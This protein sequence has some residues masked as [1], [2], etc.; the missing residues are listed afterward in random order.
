MDN[1]PILIGKPTGW[2]REGHGELIYEVAQFGAGHD[3]SAEV[4]QVA[5][6]VTPLYER[7]SGHAH[8]RPVRFY[9]F[10][11]TPGATNTR[12]GVVA[13]YRPGEKP[14]TPL[15]KHLIAHELFHGWLGSDFVQADDTVAWFHEGFTDYLSLWH[16]A[17]SGVIDPGWFATRLIA[18][19]AEARQSPAYG[20]VAFAEKGINWRSSAN[21][22]LAYRGGAVLAFLIDVGL[23]KQG[24]PGLMQLV[25]D[26]GA[27][28]LKGPPSLDEI[29][30]WMERHGLES[31]YKTLVG[32]K[33][34]P[35]IADTLASIGF[36]PKDVPVELTYF[37]IRVE[38]D[39]IAELDPKGPAAQAGFRIGDRIV[40]RFPGSRAEP[41][42][43]SERLT[44]P[45]RYGLENV[46]PGVAGTYLDVQ[47]GAEELTI[48]VQPRVIQGGLASRYV[49]DEAKLKEFFAFRLARPE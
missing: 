25:A 18:I 38:K 8:G 49:A 22:K 48:R 41:V 4:M 35:P 10:E 15:Y 16:C 47:R 26:L 40:G 13:S 7:H 45:Y 42:R 27:R 23:R 9:L 24:G 30:A 12:S 44:T 31:I 29:R 1:T 14:L 39:R 43:I 20:K 34:L 17:A 36:S 32:G 3:R 28:N 6:S 2:R 46:E 37:G 21:E 5:R 33:E 19:D 11:G